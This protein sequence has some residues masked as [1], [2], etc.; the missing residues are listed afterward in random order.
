MTNTSALVGLPPNTQDDY[1]IIRGILRYM[2]LDGDPA[3]GYTMQPIISDIEKDESEVASILLGLVMSLV[4]MVSVSC[5]RLGLR[6]FRPALRWGWDDWILIPAV[7]CLLNALTVLT[8]VHNKFHMLMTYPS[9]Y[10]R[11]PT[12][13]SK[14]ELSPEEEEAG[15]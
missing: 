14:L 11:H 10:F 8:C 12:H 9:S 7:V 4:V 3:R 6:L 1:W 15:I 13:A 2:E 5:A